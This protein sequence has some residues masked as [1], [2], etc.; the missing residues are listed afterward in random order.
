V[1]LWFD[2]DN[3]PDVNVFVPIMRRLPDHEHIVT[4]RKFASLEQ[5]ARDRGLDVRSVGSHSGSSMLAKGL[6]TAARTVALLRTLPRFDAAVG[7]VG[8]PMVWTAKLRG[9][10]SLCFLDNDLVTSNLRL[11]APFIDRLIVPRAFREEILQRLGLADRTVRYDGFKE[12]LAV[13]DFEP[14]SG[15]LDALPFREYVV[16]RPEALQ[17]EYVSRNARS[18]VPEILRRFDAAGVNVLYLARDAADRSHARPYPRVHVPAGAIN[19]LDA[20]YF[21]KAVLTGS[22][23]LAREAAVLGVPA[24]SFFPGSQ[25]LS[26]DQEMVRRSWMIHSREP[27]EL[28]EA[29][30]C[31]KRRPFDRDRAREVLEGV[32]REIRSSVGG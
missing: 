32:V 7:G 26:V 3:F 19:G 11:S 29:V 18:I 4:T 31:A 23:T 25:L 2:L 16:V 27:E 8:A 10:R 17:A 13:A 1:R 21:S 28:V 22:G 12:D 30:L 5:L 9:K 14:S 20:C 6:G 15:F 24:A